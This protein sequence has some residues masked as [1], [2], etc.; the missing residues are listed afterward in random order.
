[1]KVFIQDVARCCGCYNCQIACKDE[2]CGND[3]MPYAKP[4]PEIGQFWCKINEFIRGTVPKVEMHYISQRCNHCEDAACI[5][6]CP[7][8]A[9]Y[10]REDGLVIIDPAKCTG[11]RLCVTACPYGNIYFNENLSVAQKCTGCAHILDRG[12]PIKEPRCVDNCPNLDLKFGEE[13]D[14]SA[15]IAQAEVMNPEFGTNPRHYYLNVPKKF[16]A[17]TVYD[18]AAEEVI[19]GA[20]CTL[21]GDTSGAVTTN[22]FGDFW[23]RN[24]PVGTFSLTIEADGKTKTITDI[25]TESDVNLGDIALS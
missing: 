11:C 4:Q 12:W 25:S 22:D 15:E 23:F 18:P 21:S 3:W 8:E 16:I 20:N 13:A 24:L 19:I 5:E 10:K 6:S 14:F 2:H 17:G 1:M 7:V 9:I